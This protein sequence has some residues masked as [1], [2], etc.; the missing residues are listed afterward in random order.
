MTHTTQQQRRR[1][2]PKPSPPLLLP[3]F[4][5]AA[6]LLRAADAQQGFP[7]DVR[8]ETRLGVLGLK[9]D[10]DATVIERKCDKMLYEQVALRIALDDIAHQNYTILDVSEFLPNAI[11][12][13]PVYTGKT[14]GEIVGNVTGWAKK[15]IGFCAQHELIYGINTTESVM[16]H[17][18]EEDDLEKH[19]V[20]LLLGPRDVVNY[21]CQMLK[22]M[23]SLGRLPMVTWGC[24]PEELGNLEPGLPTTSITM[25][26]EYTESLRSHAIM[27]FLHDHN[28]DKGHVA[29]IYDQGNQ[30]ILQLIQAL[31]SISTCSNGPHDVRIHA[32]GID[33]SSEQE[34][35]EIFEQIAD[36]N[37]NIILSDMSFLNLPHALYHAREHGLVG[38]DNIWIFTKE[39]TPTQLAVATTE[40]VCDLLE[41]HE[42]AKEDKD[43]KFGELLHGS[44][45]VGW[46]PG[47]ADYTTMANP[48][49]R[50][51]AVWSEQKPEDYPDLGLPEDFFDY[52]PLSAN[53]A[54]VYDAAWVGIV[55]YLNGVAKRGNFYDTRDSNMYDV[56]TLLTNAATPSAGNN[57]DLSEAHLHVCADSSAD[58]FRV[59]LAFNGVTGSISFNEDSHS[60]KAIAN[61]MN[62]VNLQWGNNSLEPYMYGKWPY[63]WNSE[64]D[65]LCNFPDA[66]LWERRQQLTPLKYGS[67]EKPPAYRSSYPTSEVQSNTDDKLLLVIG[68]LVATLSLLGIGILYLFFRY[69]RAH[70]KILKNEK[71]AKDFQFEWETNAGKALT[72]LSSL[73]DTMG[74]KNQ[75]GETK[76][77]HEEKLAQIKRFLL[78]QDA[79]VEMKSVKSSIEKVGAERYTPE[80]TAYLMAQALNNSQEEAK[81]P[82]YTRSNSFQ[83]CQ[84]E[85]SHIENVLN[86]SSKNNVHPSGN[87][88]GD[89]SSSSNNDLLMRSYSSTSSH[90][91]LEVISPVVDSVILNQ[92]KSKLIAS[93]VLAATGDPSFD[94]FELA[95]LT[96]DRPLSTLTLYLL[97]RGGVCTALRLNRQKMIAFVVEVEN[98]M[99]EHP[100][101]NRRHVAD[102]VAGIYAFTLPGGCLYDLVHTS[103]LALLSVVF[104]ATVHDLQHTGVNNNYLTRTLHPLA[105]RHSDK[106]VN[107]NH[108]LSCAF[109]LLGQDDFKFMEVYDG[110]DYLTF[111]SLVIEMV[112]ATDMKL[113]FNLLGRFRLIE[114]KVEAHQL[115]ENHHTGGG[116]VVAPQ[117]PGAEGLEALLPE[118]ISLC[119]Q[120]ALKCADIGHVYCESNV[121]LRWVQKLEQEFFAQGDRE[122]EMGAV[123]KSPL[124]DRDKAGITK[125]QCGFF[126][127]V[128]LPL[129]KSFSTAF[130]SVS[131]VIES[132]ETNLALWAKIEEEQ[133]EISEVFQPKN[134]AGL[135]PQSRHHSHKAI[136]D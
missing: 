94:V 76:A 121:H 123:Q 67:S 90:E 53:A 74:D 41:A 71:V 120:V 125:S 44:F 21:E 64:W 16:L 79:R 93:L 107:E 91:T 55:T 118:D 13:M 124:M 61:I 59:G 48:W 106:S 12:T 111:R 58:D 4:L 63:N 69:R 105:I 113:H 42:C 78:A 60:R 20:D 127:V 133:L 73:I 112:L 102:V 34:M 32:Y 39:F 75:S 50:F 2:R 101:H 38:T 72:M 52:A 37:F 136:V 51:Q 7:D 9:P 86:K 110:D 3:L 18:I 95:T 57:S 97:H 33:T 85:K 30:K 17:R 82:N 29:V 8:M 22:Q 23:A 68:I 109:D 35:D 122:A 80:V 49:E 36:G 19:T 43:L 45:A 108:H 24:T 54:L 134:A 126:K 84:I 129:F 40:N 116:T 62:A 81:V 25:L 117:E 83:K 27:D 11:R 92:V 26:P 128:V 66:S 100:Y 10:R 114:K 89:D 132:I 103:P 135:I 130:P 104:A 88:T 46:T 1:R 31:N 28:W 47:G 96:G 15:N 77:S 56:Q 5:A 119:F 14:M 6:L 87:S 99:F 131:P 115:S 70:K 65:G 98:M